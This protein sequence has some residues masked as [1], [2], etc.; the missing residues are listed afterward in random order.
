M[1]G[2]LFNQ[3]PRMLLLASLTLI[4][5]EPLQK[6]MINQRELDVQR[7]DVLVAHYIET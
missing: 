4:S 2:F 3:H 5:F 7:Q 1:T 6:E